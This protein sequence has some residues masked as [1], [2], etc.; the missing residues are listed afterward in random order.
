[1]NNIRRTKSG[2]FQRLINTLMLGLFAGVLASLVGCSIDSK[3]SVL[4]AK[5]TGEEHQKLVLDTKRAI[6]NLDINL[7]DKLTSKI[8]VNRLL[9][10]DSSLLAW[11]VETQ[12]PILVRLLLDKGAMTQIANDN[13]FGPLIQACR[14]GNSE[15]I[16]DLLDDGANPNSKIE[17]GTSAFHLCA[18]S[19]TT[20][21]LAK[22]VSQ[23]AKIKAANE[24]GQTALMWAANLGNVEN[25]NYLVKNGANINQQTKEGY[26]PLFF[27]IKS[28][29]LNVV[30]AMV[31]LGADV[32]AQAKD[33]T[34]AMQL[35]VYTNNYPFLTWFSAELKSL[36]SPEEIQQTLTAYDRNGY[37]LLHAAVT[38]NQPQLVSNLLALGANSKT[39]SEPSKLRWRYEANFKTEDYFPPQLTP[40]EI[41]KQKD[42]KTII[43]MLEKV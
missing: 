41:A 18:G 34:T 37:Q 36:M 42:F 6:L 17:D 4:E 11:A 21:L 9:P 2:K 3:P 22:M 26:T 38:A 1:M 8:D 27:A 19:T 43:L 33:G 10:D 16:S 35:A 13:R 32:L 23:G 31:S 40:M 28:R 15:I 29:N 12:E 20:E 24:Y 30:Q 25:V 7:V 39:V 14:Y 5:L